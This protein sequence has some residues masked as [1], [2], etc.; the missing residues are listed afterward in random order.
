ME[1]KCRNCRYWG[2][3]RSPFGG[4]MMRICIKLSREWPQ[5]P[6]SNSAFITNDWD[7]DAQFNC[8]PDFRCDYFEYP[9]GQG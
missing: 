5:D 1:P 8:G 4:N 7:S 3:E 9:P 6:K 2:P